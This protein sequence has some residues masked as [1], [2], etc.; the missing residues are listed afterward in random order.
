MKS[1]TSKLSIIILS[2]MAMAFTFV[3]GSTSSKAVSDETGFAQCVANA[4]DHKGEPFS[5]G[6]F[7]ETPN[8]PN[9]WFQ[10]AI[11]KC[12]QDNQ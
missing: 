7:M 3:L 12:A 6:G 4:R 11:L 8:R 10:L 2:L 9:H 1:I 5:E